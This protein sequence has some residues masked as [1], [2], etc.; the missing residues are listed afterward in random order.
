[1]QAIWLKQRSGGGQQAPGC[2]APASQPASAPT[3]LA[4]FLH[5]FA[6][7][8]TQAERLRTAVATSH[9]HDCSFL[10]RHLS[11]YRR[12]CPPHGCYA[13]AL[14]AWR[15]TCTDSRGQRCC[16]SQARRHATGG[17]ASACKGVGTTWH[18]LN[19]RAVGAC[20]PTLEPVL[21]FTNRT[22]GLHQPGPLQ[23]AR[24]PT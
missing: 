5:T 15:T 9:S 8:G 6:S 13:R 21:R 16:T 18:T 2:I 4:S 14:C 10:S 22:S 17:E 12:F 23:S 11:H 7:H 20:F 1:M 24:P 19:A 3:S